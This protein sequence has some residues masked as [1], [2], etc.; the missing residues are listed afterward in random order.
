MRR[1]WRGL[2]LAVAMPAMAGAGELQDDLR[3]RRARVME[4]L[5]PESILVH[6]SAPTRVYSRDVDYEYRQDSDLCT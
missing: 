5:G 4:A 3:T 2:L 6:W 1:A